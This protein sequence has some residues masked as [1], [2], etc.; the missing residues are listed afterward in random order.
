M[1]AGALPPPG[2]GGKTFLVF[3]NI[4]RYFGVIIAFARGLAVTLFPH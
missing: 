3:Q 2:G 4:L 1:D